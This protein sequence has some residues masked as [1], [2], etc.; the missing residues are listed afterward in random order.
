M[1]SNASWSD[2]D[3]LESDSYFE[4]PDMENLCLMAESDSKEDLDEVND[5]LITFDE[6]SHAYDDLGGF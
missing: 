3:L 2:D 1:V 4:D 5:S 6:L